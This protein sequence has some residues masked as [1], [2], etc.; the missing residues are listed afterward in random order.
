ME[1]GDEEFCLF[2]NFAHDNLVVP[3][4]YETFNELENIVPCS[5]TIMWLYKDYH[6]YKGFFEVCSL[7]LKAQS[8]LKVFFTIYQI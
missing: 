7:D 2:E 6:V 5:C 4:F 1:F 3:L 8:L